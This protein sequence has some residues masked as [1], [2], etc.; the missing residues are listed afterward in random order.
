MSDAIIATKG[1][2]FTIFPK[3]PIELRAAIWEA[4]LIPRTVEIRYQTPNSHGWSSATELPAAL[5]VCKESREIISPLYPLCFGG[6]IGSYTP[7]RV[8]FNF[9]IDTVYLPG[10]TRSFVPHFIGIMNHIELR[11][12]R[13]LA[14]HERHLFY[15]IRCALR[16]L[17]GLH[18]LLVVCIVGKSYEK[19]VNNCRLSVRIFD[20]VPKGTCLREKLDTKE[21]QHLNVWGKSICRSVY[22][23]AVEK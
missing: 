22:G 19:D 7:P 17:R 15:D 21:F 2:Q 8:R 9:A 11:Q 3:L 10:I 23:Y 18:E 13:S 1:K 12:L 14:I 20:E 4:T 5:E 16:S 6:K